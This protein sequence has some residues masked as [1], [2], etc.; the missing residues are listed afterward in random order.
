VG[1][2]SKRC[3]EPSWEIILGEGSFKRGGHKKT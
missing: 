3:G 1:I 2:G